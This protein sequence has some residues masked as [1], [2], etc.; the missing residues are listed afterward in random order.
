M[1]ASVTTSAWRNVEVGRVVLFSTGPFT[2]RL[3]AI[4]EIIDHKRVLIE[5]PSSKPEAV[6]PRHA[7]SLSHVSLTPVVIEKLPRASGHGALKAAWEKAGVEK[8][9]ENSAW[10]QNR[11]RSSKRKQ[12]SDFERFKVMRL[13]KQA[14]FEVRKTVAAARTAKA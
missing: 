9:W 10:A 13:R 14:R 1:S 2:G 3:A 4:V 7:I 5:G 8:S 12:L 6:V 11:E